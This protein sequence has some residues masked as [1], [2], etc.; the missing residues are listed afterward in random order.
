MT[1]A[2]RLCLALLLVPLALA[3][4]VRG[5]E[6]KDKD[7]PVPEKVSYYKDIRPIFQQHCQGCHQPAKQQGGYVMTEYAGLLKAGDQAEPGVVPGKPDKSYLVEQITPSKGE[8]KP[9]MP[10][11][12]DA[13]PKEEV[14]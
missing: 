9:K 6:K 3:G 1:R 8:K 11:N 4:A 2:R 7:G 12:R 5:Q 10:K 14:D 13:L